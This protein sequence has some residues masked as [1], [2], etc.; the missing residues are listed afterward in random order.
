LPEGKK[1]ELHQQLTL[2]KKLKAK[3][4]YKN[5]SHFID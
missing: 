1:Q 4:A 2:Y 3:S 5:S